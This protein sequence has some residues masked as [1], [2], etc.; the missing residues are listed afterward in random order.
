[1]SP[2]EKYVGMFWGAV[3]VLIGAAFLVTRSISFTITNPWLGM[4]LTAGLSLA[5]FASY[6]LSGPEKWGWLFPAC[7]FAGTTVTVL[8]TQFFP[9]PQ[10]GWI[11]APVLLSI[12]VPFLVH[13][14]IKE[15]TDYAARALPL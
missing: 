10:C 13:V 4:A 14:G 12:A 1:M 9:N 5:F 15:P 7:I 2:K 8:F 3:L 6:F 11:G